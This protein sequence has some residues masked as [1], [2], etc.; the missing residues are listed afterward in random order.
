MEPGHSGAIR[1]TPREWRRIW[2]GGTVE[3][4]DRELMEAVQ[5]DEPRAFED[6]VRR[7]QRRFYRVA[8]RYLREHQAA[9]D[10][11]QEAFIKIHLA[12]HR[13]EPRAQP[14][15]WAY[16]IVTNHCIDLLRKESKYRS[17]SLD[18]EE[19][20]LPRLLEDTRAVSPDRAVQ[21]GELAKM[22]WEALGRLPG[23]QKEILVLRH[24]EEMSLQEI[25]DYKDCPLGT[26][27]SA[28]HRATRS[29]KQVLLDTEVL[30]H[31]SL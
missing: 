6:F 29:L 15:T 11:V 10:A 7:Y 4:S 5:R 3:P 12:R 28:L 8:F 31:E 25:A 2:S 30:A 16:R 26:V 19:S 1:A 9:L 13:W 23:P 14:F 22:V 18:D 20:P 24:F 27:K 17:E 21:R